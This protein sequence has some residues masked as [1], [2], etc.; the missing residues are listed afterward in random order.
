MS[1]N[2]FKFV[3]PGIF[4][5]EVDNS[6]L[7][8]LPEELGPV[9]IGRAERGPSMVPVKIDSFSEFVETFG[10]PIA[11]GEGDDVWR[12]GNRLGPT[13]AAFA[14]Q[15]YL[16]SASPIT[17][18]R[19]LGEANPSVASA[20]TTDAQ[21]GWIAHQAFGLFL[22]TDDFSTTDTGR[23]AAILYHQDDDASAN[24]GL[25][26]AVGD[27]SNDVLAIAS[28]PLKLAVTTVDGAATSA[29]IDLTVD[30][31][32]ATTP[33]FSFFQL[34]DIALNEVIFGIDT[35]TSTDVF[36]INPGAPD[37]Y[38]IGSQSLL[39]TDAIA[40]R[41]A[42]IV[43]TQ[44][45]IDGITLNVT[46]SADGSKVTFTQ[47]TTGPLGAA[48]DFLQEGSS[49]LTRS[50]FVNGQNAPAPQVSQKIAFNMDENSRIYLRNVLNTNPT[51]T[52]STISTADEKY[53]LGH[54]FDQFLEGTTATHACIKALPSGYENFKT[55]ASAP[56]TPWFVSQHLGD[57]T[58]FAG[59][60]TALEAKVQ[61]L[62]KLHALYSGDWEQKNFKI[63][64]S[65]VAAPKNSF[66]KY[67]TFSVLVRDAKDT[68]AA[69]II[70][71]RFS[72]CD[73][74]P[75]SSNYIGVK[76]GDQFMRWSETERRYIQEGQY[77]NQSRFVRVEISSDIESGAADASLL[78]FG[79]KGPGKDASSIIAGIN[80]G[81]A[82]TK[83]FPS[84]KLRTATTD[85]KLGSPKQAFFGVTSSDS[86]ERF[87]PSYS[88]IARKIKKENPT[89]DSFFFSLDLIQPVKNPDDVAQVIGATLSNVATDSS[90]PA[91]TTAFSAT[92]TYESVLEAGYDKFTAP[93]TGGFDGLDITE[94]EPFND[95]F[96][97]SATAESNYAFNSMKKAIDTVSD[98]EVVEC[99]LMAIPGVAN[100]GITSHLI[101]TCENRADALAV[102]DIEKDYTP[103][104][105]NKASEQ[106]RLPQVDLAVSTLRDRRIN[107]S[108]GCAY[109]PWVQVRDS[110]SNKLVWMP[111]SVAAIGT[112]ASSAAKS[113]L[114]F[115][116]AGFT[117]GGLSNGAAGLPV[118][119]TRYRLTSKHRD[120]LYE[121]N[122][123]PIAQFPA[124]GIVI[125][126][127]KT[128]QVT[129]SALD[130]INV[131]RLMVY[132]KKEISRMAATL[133]FDQNVD[134]TWNRF[135]S[136]AEPFLSSVKS[137]FGLTEY[138][139][140]LDETTTTPELV[141]R[142]IVYAKV[143]LKP[144]RAIEF[145]AIDFVITNTGASF[146]D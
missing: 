133:L 103:R 98:P 21:A 55:S 24:L 116:P 107:S 77:L 100:P 130:R 97:T 41:I 123:N 29:V 2:S 8:R 43:N 82:L 48:D 108:Y 95:I 143:F 51:L 119:Q 134:T 17:F 127:Q 69:P 110:L 126:G 60:P 120:S 57:P 92:G 20:T 99:N 58:A 90:E 7:P 94:I 54:T 146:D 25:V 47:D 109:F 65:D 71:E 28:N 145:I 84:F 36:N 85:K 61:K 125:F 75:T 101:S 138:R 14:A 136:K 56:E 129:P 132:V 9:I 135:L 106:N 44:L 89:D 128:L 5:N 124:E 18:V 32:P 115:A 64:I 87:D 16:K 141:D 142:N 76:I 52:N 118:V 6:Q 46:A 139:V 122:I 11:G 19:L 34:K 137:R 74:D 68:D 81:S 86:N 26:N 3:S 80:S 35:T 93:L 40:S 45:A 13:Y 73:L 144:A 70:Y 79:F 49:A 105:W 30:S 78:P 62:F 33:L 50:G 88:D 121:A 63:S 23:L 15:A 114:W 39:T 53:F 91:S 12:Q 27:S 102:I 140:V 111:P 4:I 113:E 104:G 37:D 22:G 112:M 10:N 131:R 72:S 66:T 1:V 83:A 59:T 38:T 31:V 96:T 117:R 42:T 67:G